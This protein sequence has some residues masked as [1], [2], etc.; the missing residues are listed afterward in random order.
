MTLGLAPLAGDAQWLRVAHTMMR[1]FYNFEELRAFKA[2]L[3]PDSWDPIY[4]A[5]P[6][7][8]TPLVAI[9]DALDAFAGG[10][11]VRFGLRALFRAPAPV[12]FGLGVLLIPWIALMSAV[13]AKRWF[14]SR[15][16]Q[17]AWVAFDVALC[18]AL[19]SL[20]RRWRRDLAIAT[21][22][23]AAADAVLTTIE[24]ARYNVRR[25]RRASDALIV[26]AAIAAP[27]TAA[28]ILFGGLRRRSSGG[29]PSRRATV[30][31]NE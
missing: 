13:D 11:I 8:S 4:L 19:V 2:K 18:G 14:P 21:C 7:G 17:F 10:A 31:F 28:A 23:A 6:D 15:F 27:F 16:V 24:V 12:V 26:F 1:G 5:W 9:D 3:R 22:T 30:L 20:S 25:M 29:K